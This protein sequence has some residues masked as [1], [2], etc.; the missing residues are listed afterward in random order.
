MTAI[1]NTLYPSISAYESGFLK[2]DD[3]HELYWEVSGNPKGVPVVVLHGGP[4][5][6]ASPKMRQFFD[7]K[8]YKIVIFDQRGAG[9]SKPIG[10]IKDNT[11]D[12]L[13]EDIETLRV[14][15]N[16]E[17]WHVFGGSWGSTLGLL[18]AIKHPSRVLSLILRGLFLM[19]REE[20]EWFMSGMG[21]FFPES[22]E[23]FLNYL[24]EDKRHDPLHAYY[25]ILTCGDMEKELE[26]GVMW[27]QY[28]GECANLIPKA[29]NYS[30]EESRQYARALSRLE[31]HYFIHNLFTPDNYILQNVDAIR[32]IPFTLVQGRYDV[33]CPI[34]TAYQL[35]KKWPEMDLVTVAQGGHSS[36]DPDICKAL[37]EATEKTKHL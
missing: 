37:I 1:K 31:A 30:S 8:Y 24:P 27:C 25:E 12:H 36:G 21:H 35:K 14:F 23:K 4:G 32:H 18:Y 29:E 5:G 19:Q 34:K 6:G 15:L 11:P 16:I 33:I 17:K 7:P 22:Y 20:V 28:E 10:E 26:S 13:V 2:V 9:R 3:T